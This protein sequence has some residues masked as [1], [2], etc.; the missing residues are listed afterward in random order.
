M[1]LISMQL[2]KASREL[3]ALNMAMENISPWTHK[4]KGVVRFYNSDASNMELSVIS[5]LTKVATAALRILKNRLEKKERKYD[6]LN[7]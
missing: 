6:A 7:R 2:I 4:E 1:P 5:I 3:E